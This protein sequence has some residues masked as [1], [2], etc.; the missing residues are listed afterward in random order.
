VPEPRWP[1]PER[2]ARCVRVADVTLAAAE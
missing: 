2:M 1:S